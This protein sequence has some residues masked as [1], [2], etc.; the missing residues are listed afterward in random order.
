MIFRDLTNNSEKH[1]FAKNNAYFALKMI[2]PD[3]DKMLDP[4]YFKFEI[5]QVHY[6][7]SLSSGY[8]IYLFRKTKNE[9]MMISGKLL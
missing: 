7:R 9:V 6:E 4:T 1:Y 8:L 5:K 3:A 2:G